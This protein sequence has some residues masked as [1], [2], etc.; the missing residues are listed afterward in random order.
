MDKVRSAAPG[1][2]VIACLI[3]G[4]GGGGGSDNTAV[5]GS[6]SEPPIAAAPTPSSNPARSPPASPPAAGA[7]TPAPA[8]P[9]AAP[10]PVP[11]AQQPGDAPAA[12]NSVPGLLVWAALQK[13]VSPNPIAEP[14]TNYR[15]VLTDN[16]EFIYLGRNEQTLA[17]ESHSFTSG[18]VGLIKD[19]LVAVTVTGSDG[20]ID[21]VTANGLTMVGP[22]VD[23]RRVN[24]LLD[25]SAGRW[26][27]GDS[28]VDLVVQ[29]TSSEDQ[30]R[31]CW[32]VQLP[33][34]ETAPVQTSPVPLRRLMCGVYSKTVP[35][36]DVG[37]YVV[38]DFN[39]TIRTF[40]GAW[41]IE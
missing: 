5:S 30:M 33:P 19:R 10:T 16:R 13:G 20:V 38:D 6:P 26:A 7:P 17:L 40:R 22:Q 29:S 8:S 15:R 37:G 2:V 12:A 35:G 23:L 36:L 21:A 9:P 34:P 14:N 3:A 32:N 41:N 11:P 39:G 1:L 28:F 24:P 27:N 25:E 31:V 18:M 4:C